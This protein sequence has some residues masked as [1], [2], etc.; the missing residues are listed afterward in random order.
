VKTP[1]YEVIARKGYFASRQG[2]P[3]RAP[4]SGGLTAIT[5]VLPDPGVPLRGIAAPLRQQD[6]AA[7]VAITL[8]FDRT[9]AGADAGDAVEVLTHLFDP[10]GRPRANFEQTATLCASPG[11]CEMTSLIAATPG[12]HAVRIGVKH[13]KSGQTGSVYLDVD[14]PDFGKRALTMTGLM[15]EATPAWP[16]T[17]DDRVRALIP[18]LPTTRRQF[19]SAD[20]VTIFFRIHQRPGRAPKEVTRTLRITNGRDEVVTTLSE[21]ISAAAFA[22]FGAEQRL[23]LPTTA[24]GPGQYLVSVEL[25]ARGEQ[26]FE[27]Q[28]SLTLR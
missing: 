7:A 18:V 26:T 22:A 8:A 17:S 21:T 24:L 25:T 16:R 10:E 12:R 4:L 6:G 11:W 27:R 20:S 1:G 9:A 15:L 5:G 2:D 3:E 28:L 19:A 14:V 13:V 23:V